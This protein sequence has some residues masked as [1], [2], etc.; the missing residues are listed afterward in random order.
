M[1]ATNTVLA[2]AMAKIVALK[3]D[4]NKTIKTIKLMNSLMPL[5]KSGF[6]IFSETAFGLNKEESDAVYSEELAH[7]ASKCTTLAELHEKFPEECSE[8]AAK[9]KELFNKGIFATQEEMTKVL[10]DELDLQPQ[11]AEA[12][13]AELGFPLELTAG[14]IATRDAYNEQQAA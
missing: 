10:Q 6:Q 3:G 4:Y 14:Q 7:G 5:P 1:T 11:V 9:C 12:Y 8:F 2:S 13:V